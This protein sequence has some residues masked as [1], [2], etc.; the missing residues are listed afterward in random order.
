MLIVKGIFSKY[1]SPMYYIHYCVF[2]QCNESWCNSGLCTFLLACVNG[3]TTRHES[4]PIRNPQE[5][6]A[7]PFFLRI[8]FPQCAAQTHSR[9][10]REIQMCT[11][12]QADKL[13]VI[14]GRHGRKWRQFSKELKDIWRDKTD[15]IQ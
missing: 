2:C 1:N 8:L 12:F 6:A 11:V 10:R 5:C 15:W 14:L 9:Q 13:T 4:S 7:L 3:I